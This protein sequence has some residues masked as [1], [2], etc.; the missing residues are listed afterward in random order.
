MASEPIV[1]RL[2]V[3]LSWKAWLKAFFIHPTVTAS[4]SDSMKLVRKARRD[5]QAAKKERKAEIDLAVQ[6]SLL[7]S[8]LTDQIN[9]TLSD[10][11]DNIDQLSDISDLIDSEE[12]SDQQKVAKAWQVIH[13]IP[14]SDLIIQLRELF[15]PL[16]IEEYTLCIE[17][18][19]RVDSS[20]RL[21]LETIFA[22]TDAS[23]WVNAV[24]DIVD[25]IPDDKLRVSLQSRIDNYKNAVGYIPPR[26]IP[27]D[28]KEE[29]S[30][31][32]YVNLYH[33]LQ[34][35]FLKTFGFDGYESTSTELM[36]AEGEQYSYDQGDGLSAQFPTVPF[37][38][39]LMTFLGFPTRLHEGRANLGVREI[40]RNLFGGWDNLNNGKSESWFW[41]FNPKNYTFEGKRL[42]NVIF[43]P[44]KLVIFALKLATLPLKFALNV[45]K[46]ITEFLPEVILNYSAILFGGAASTLLV[47]HYDTNITLPR[48]IFTG[49]LAA[50]FF[51]ITAPI[52][53]A[54]RLFALV[55]TAA[56]SP[57]KSV[58][59]AWNYGRALNSRLGY[60]FAFIGTAISIV[61]TATLWAIT[62]PLVFAKVLVLFPALAPLVTSMA[63][64]P[65]VA[66][67]LVYLNGAATLVAGT[68][69]AAF[70]L[71]ATAI[72]TAFGVSV[73]AMTL[74]VATTVAIIVAPVASIASRAM[75]ALSNLW[76][77]WQTN[78]PLLFPVHAE[79]KFTKLGDPA[80]KPAAKSIEKPVLQSA[81]ATL[82]GV[83]SPSRRAGKLREESYIRLNEARTAGDA[84]DKQAESKQ[85]TAQTPQI[86]APGIYC[87]P[88][89]EDASPHA[90]IG[91]QVSN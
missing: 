57:E 80:A 27:N 52:H 78:A 15:K 71:A 2:A 21:G 61:L 70:S 44:I 79:V 10:N 65:I 62:F 50:L 33:I 19:S 3:N 14:D 75:D 4:A 17:I 29:P 85:Y 64:W 36:D 18:A 12:L 46:L 58:R 6:V 51:I 1:S 42:W 34:G 66:K 76:T 86:P 69:P 67:T 54:A 90:L 39:A 81:L 31:V 59:M 77:K 43:F 8:K 5:L 48:K 7:L 82:P 30:L 55:G 24:T 63:Q 32:S 22:R 41:W 74:A 9:D 88:P 11:S 73:S 84:A 25:R 16:K 56:T 35:S 13:S 87:D 89:R 38:L 23:Q 68:V 53:Y 37:S 40:I 49:V 47:L 72:S 20:L 45:L 28:K 26:A 60:V 91:R 83:C